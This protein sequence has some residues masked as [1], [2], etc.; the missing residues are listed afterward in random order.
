MSV[1]IQS[2]LILAAAASLAIAVGIAAS[3]PPAAAQA[4]PTAAGGPASPLCASGAQQSPVD[5]V[6]AIE[7]DTPPVGFNWSVTRGGTVTNTGS[8]LEVDL[9]L[10]GSLETQGQSYTLKGFHF[11][12]PSEH[13]IEGRKFP[14][15]IHLVHETEAGALA[16]VGVLVQ[17]GPPL[18]QLDPI[19]ATTPVRPGAAQVLF[20]ID[21]LRLIP[22]DR[23]HYLYEGSTTTPPCSETA[24]WIVMASPISASR[25]QIEAYLQLFS[26][27]ARP[28]QPLNRRYILKSRSFTPPP[29]AQP[30]EPQRLERPQRMVH[31]GP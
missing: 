21:P 30:Q 28:V 7:A 8:T 22:G 26:S 25:A 12:T 16:I 4:G 15:E 31:K 29:S 11:H 1:S 2:S 13:T 3:G 27:N 10:S 17:E 9:S 18:D 5:L 24:T 14:L 19:W 6:D 20:E 23:T